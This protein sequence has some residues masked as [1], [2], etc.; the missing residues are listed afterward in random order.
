MNIEIT[1]TNAELTVANIQV[2]RNSLELVTEA[3]VTD[4]LKRLCK[5]AFMEYIGMFLELGMPKQAGEMQQKRLVS[6]IK[7]YYLDH[8]PCEREIEQIFQLTPSQSKTLL[9]NVVGR[10]RN[11]LSAQINNT[12]RAVIHSASVVSG[13]S[14]YEFECESEVVF[15]KLNAIV[16]EKG[17]G[18]TAIQKVKDVSGK[19]YCDQDT[20]NLLTSQF[21]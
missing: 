11:P 14:R 3:D 8:V 10:Y 13:T 6:M 18:L 17:R 21:P 15:E 2:L 1:I 19:Y 16:K 5:T 9:K 20:Y 4:A 7:F 12:L